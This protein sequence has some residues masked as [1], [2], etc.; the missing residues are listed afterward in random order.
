[1]DDDEEGVSRRGEGRGWTAEGVKRE[2]GCKS[3]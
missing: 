2:E 1:M 3:I